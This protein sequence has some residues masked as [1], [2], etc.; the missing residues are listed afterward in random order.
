[1]AHWYLAIVPLLVGCHAAPSVK[2]PPGTGGPVSVKRLGRG[3]ARVT[4]EVRNLTSTP[5]AYARWFGLGPEPVPYCRSGEGALRLCGS[6]AMLDEAGN[7]WIHESY[8]KPGQ[9][10]RFVAHPGSATAVGVL[11]W[12]GGKET[13]VWSASYP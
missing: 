2:E 6:K 1:M 4:F 5:V 8:L 7:L 10:V 9:R 3:T 11:L 13:Y 12:V